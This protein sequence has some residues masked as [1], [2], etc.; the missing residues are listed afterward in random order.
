MYVLSY[1]LE[2]LDYFKELYF[3]FYSKAGIYPIHVM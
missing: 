2:I 1:I 3:S